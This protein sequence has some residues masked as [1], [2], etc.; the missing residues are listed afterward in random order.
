MAYKP[1]I[2]NEVA[3]GTNQSSFTAGDIL[4]AS[5]ANT[6]SKLGVGSNGDVLT[7]DTGLPAWVAPAVYGDVNGPA[8]SVAGN[9]ASFSDTSG[10]VIADSGVASG[11]VLV[12]SDI[13]ST[14]QPYSA[15]VAFAAYLPSSD[16]NVTGNG[17]VYTLGSGNALTITQND[18][19]AF[20]TAGVFTA[21][22]TAWYMIGATIRVNGISSNNAEMV[23]QINSTPLV[24]RGGIIG[25]SARTSANSV[26]CQI[27]QALYLS[28]ME[29]VT[30]E[31]IGFGVMNV[32][33]I[34]GT[35]SSIQ[36]TYCYGF[37]L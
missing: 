16:N 1:Q 15:R 17:T 19:N 4:Y 22:E 32:L 36:Q 18:G 14:I 5:A 33:D 8:S 13:G 34:S 35:S 9:L 37:K 6:L 3:G 11:D 30:F 25:G 20:T 21:P 27:H 23:M 29:T 28:A 2:L 31:V 24:Y 12:S 10:K 26:T 7:L